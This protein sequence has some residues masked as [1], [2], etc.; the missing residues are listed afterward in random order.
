MA[1]NSIFNRVLINEKKSKS[2]LK[3][4]LINLSIN[5]L[6]SVVLISG[7]FGL[8]GRLIGQL[9]GNIANV[10]AIQYEFL[11]KRYIRYK[12]LFYWPMV[13]ETIVLAI[14]SVLTSLQSL[15]LFI[16]IVFF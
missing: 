6:I 15:L 10:G 12:R 9:C 7:G 11:K 14:P 5:H 8:L 4:S 3:N 1:V 13:K 2:I 16:W